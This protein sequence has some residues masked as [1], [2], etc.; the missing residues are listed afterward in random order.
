MSQTAPAPA[1][2]HRSLS[3]FI[4]ILGWIRTYDRGAWLRPDL[5]AGVTVA[6]FSVPESMAYAGLAGLTPEHGLYASMIALLV[7]TFFGT[8]RQ[9]SVGTTSALA[10]MVAG[11]LG[12]LA[13]DPDEY[14]AAAQLTAVVAGG[15]AILAGL[16]KLGFIVNFIS[17][18]VLKGF[19]AG[20]ALYIASSQLSKLFGIEGVQGNFFERVWNVIK[21]IGE[22]NSWTLGLGIASIVLLIAFERF[23]PALPGSLIV[24]LASI[25]LMYL[26]DLQD[27][28]VT[29]A[30]DFPSGLPSLGISHLPAG[31]YS[32]IIGLAFGCFLLSYVEGIGVAKTFAARHR[33]PVDANQELYA[34]GAI[35]VASGIAQGFPVGGSMSRSA[36]NDAGG[37]KTPLAGGIAAILLG[38]VLL[39]LTGIFAKLPEATL[40]AVVLVAVRGLIDIPALKRIYRLNRGEFAA[41]MLTAAGVLTF[42]MLEGIVIGAGFSLLLLAYRGSKP[43]VDTL[44]Q[45]PGTADFA[46]TAR[47]P[48]YETI[49]GTLIVRVDGGIFYANADAVKEQVDTLAW[50]A[51]P[52]VTRLILDLDNVPSLDLSAMDMIGELRDE[53]AEHDSTFVIV[54][55]TAPVRELLRND[56]LGALLLD[57]QE[58]SSVADA[59]ER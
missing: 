11:T 9:M 8:S 31:H 58:A 28:G 14:L 6:A 30:G 48:D 23:L 21:H 19:S 52:P 13:L 59:L 20:A 44:G 55:A 42:G 2:T 1:H 33:Q 27:K 5:L 41:A 47:H 22:T 50:N 45:I 25:G 34:N 18:T 43:R 35:N 53:A 38:L 57:E 17:E 54:G 12:A 51:D 15:F 3:S 7:Y 36:V 39:F 29:V 24:V 10:I 16:F 26:S 32:D 40:A 4:P 49:P 46:S 56:G 37:A